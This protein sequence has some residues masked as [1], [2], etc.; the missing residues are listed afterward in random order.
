MEN[1]ELIDKAIEFIQHNP[2]ENLSLRDIAENAGFSY[3]YFDA[4]FKQHT[5]YSPVEYSRVYKLTRSALELR[6]T[7]KTILETALDFGY[8]GPE[9]FSRAF[10]AFYGIAP[11][12]YRKKYS[13]SR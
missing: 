13:E 3:T 7:D 2:K 4:I 5:G 6:R 1:K 11:N 10:K 12:A 8:S 9:S